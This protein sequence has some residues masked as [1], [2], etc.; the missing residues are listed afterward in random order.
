M[1][2]ATPL[3]DLHLPVDAPSKS[4]APTIWRDLY[5]LTKPRMNLLVVL[6]TL[7]GCYAAPHP[8][9]L[10]WLLVINTVIATAL[11]AAALQPATRMLQTSVSVTMASAA[12]RETT[13]TGMAA[14]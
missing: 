4:A 1:S 5:E 14:G 7:L 13:K 12:A 9:G 6:T 11:T 8:D 3:T 2:V 10:K